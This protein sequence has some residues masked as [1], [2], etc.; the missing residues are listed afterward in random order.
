MPSQP[1]RDAPVR[2]L[3][4]HVHLTVHVTRGVWRQLEGARMEERA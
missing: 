3:L 2:G 1:L 4:G